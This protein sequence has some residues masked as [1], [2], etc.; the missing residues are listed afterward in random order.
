MNYVIGGGISGLIFAFYNRDYRVITSDVGGLMKNN[1]MG[2]RLLQV[3]E[4]NKRLLDDL[5]M[6]ANIK[7]ARIGYFY[8]GKL[9]DTCSED[10]RVMYYM[11][12]RKVSKQEVPESVMSE[13]KNTIEYYDIDFNE[14]I[15]KLTKHTTLILG[16]VKRITRSHILLFDTHQKLKYNHIVSTIPAPTFYLIYYNNSKEHRENSD[17][18]SQLKFLNK[19]FIMVDIKYVKDQL[20]DFDY[21][22][23]PESKYPYHR[24]TRVSDTEAV[25]EFTGIDE[26]PKLFPEI[27]KKYI[28]IGQIQ[29]GSVETFENIMFLGRYAEWNH[30][31]K[32]QDVVKKSIE[33]SQK[34]EC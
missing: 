16:T 21:V 31:I 11:K 1:L 10:M 17:K 28:E 33:F 7:T 23:F 27:A 22:Y 26:K 2:P 5:N 6:E 15:T 19:L 29:S 9:H 18:K 25:V 4:W 30:K 20:G 34:K 13:G 32:I 8:G 24:I 14:L 12:S 3:N